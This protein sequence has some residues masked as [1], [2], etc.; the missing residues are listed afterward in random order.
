MIIKLYFYTEVSHLQFQ[1]GNIIF[2]KVEENCF[3][4]LLLWYSQIIFIVIN[5]NTLVRVHIQRFKHKIKY[6]FT[7]LSSANFGWNSKTVKKSFPFVISY[8]ILD[9]SDLLSII[10]AVL[11]PKDFIFFTISS[12]F[13]F[14]GVLIKEL[15]RALTSTLGNRSPL[16]WITHIEI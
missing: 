8:N 6:F 4:T 16:K 14:I 10:I 13:V 9:S 12:T 2:F 11:S 15:Y 3:H 5:K 1:W 7:T